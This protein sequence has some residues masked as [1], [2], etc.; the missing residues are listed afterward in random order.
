MELPDCFNEKKEHMGELV[1]LI[2]VES[3]GGAPG[4]EDV[5][6]WCNQ[7]GAVVIDR[8]YDGRRAESIR[9]MQFPE[10]ISKIYHRTK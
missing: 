8:E 7:C 2:A 5:V 10:L 1:R 3:F 9:Q 4:S 6:Y